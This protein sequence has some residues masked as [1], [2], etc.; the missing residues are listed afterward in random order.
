LQFDLLNEW[1][2]HWW[3][4]C[5]NYFFFRHIIRLPVMISG[6]SKFD[7]VFIWCARIL[8]VLLYFCIVLKY[9]EWFDWRI[10]RCHI[11]QTMIMYWRPCVVYDVCYLFNKINSYKAVI[12]HFD[13]GFIKNEVPDLIYQIWWVYVHRRWYEESET[14]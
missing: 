1:R 13:F 7:S 8:Q 12:L 11:P 10:N 6:E 4:K 14:N 9:L 5:K 3:N 2:W